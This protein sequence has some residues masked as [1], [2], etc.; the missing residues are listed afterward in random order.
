MIQVDGSSFL[1][2]L[3]SSAVGQLVIVTWFGGRG[4]VRASGAFMCVCLHLI[5]EED[6]TTV[7]DC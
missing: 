6:S 4:E 7:I 1:L 5:S 2:V 3:L